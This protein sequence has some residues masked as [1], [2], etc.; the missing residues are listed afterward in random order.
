MS[1]LIIP[2]VGPI[3][4]LDRVLFEDRLGRDGRRFKRAR[5]FDGHP[6]QAWVSYQVCDPRTGEIE[7][8]FTESMRSYTQYFL[9]QLHHQFQGNN[10][11]VNTQTDT[12]GTSRTLQSG[13]NIND[14]ILGASAQ[15][16]SGVMVGTGTTAVAA[17]DTKLQ[18][19]INHGTGSG[20][21]SYGAHVYGA[22]GV[23]SGTT[24]MSVARTFSN[25]SPSSVTPTETGIYT[26][27][28]DNVATTRYFC[29]IHDLISGGSGVAVAVGK[30]L[31]VQYT[32]TTSV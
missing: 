4:P 11:G 10:T 27:M 2:Q 30:I 31:T 13:N 9:N 3:I 12:G 15:D 25:N 18:T 29:I 23:S 8:E 14:W 32:F 28:V 20:N 19:K 21:L 7:A 1:G 5:Q 24:T 26:Q 6:M 22:A 17:T 16:N